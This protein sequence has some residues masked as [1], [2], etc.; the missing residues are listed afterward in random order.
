MY[1]LLAGLEGWA[2]DGFVQPWKK[3]ER[4]RANP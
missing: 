4:P 2:I 1:E 3:P